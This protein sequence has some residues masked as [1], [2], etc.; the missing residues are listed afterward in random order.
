M[1][2]NT[3]SYQ[4]SSGFV[5]RWT[6]KPTGQ[7]YIGIHKGHTNDGYIGS[8]KRFL[9]KWNLTDS[10]DWQREIL[11][12]GEYYKDC[13]AVEA[14]LVNDSTLMDP[15]CLNLTSGGRIGEKHLGTTRKNKCYRVKPQQVVVNGQTY[16]T[17]MQAIKK[18]NINFAELDRLIET[19]RFNEYN[20]C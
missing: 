17:R 2:F 12:E 13:T 15:L 9:S 1:L 4:K 7:Y 20:R 11:Y 3:Q 6:Y 19:S 5:Y 10:K 18:L 14:D 16:P 8:G